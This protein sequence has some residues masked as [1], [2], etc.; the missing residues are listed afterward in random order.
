MKPG[1]MFAS[2]LLWII[3]IGHLMRFTFEIPIV[4]GGMPIPNWIS[5]PA[6]VLFGAPAVFLWREQ[7]ETERGN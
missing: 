1:F 3:S 7:V 6:C 4:V 5:A 2:V